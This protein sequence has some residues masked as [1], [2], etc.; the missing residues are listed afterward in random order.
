VEKK[1][2]QWRH[3]WLKYNTNLF[4]H[5]CTHSFNRH[6]YAYCMLGVIPVVWDSSVS[7]AVI[8]AIIWAY[9]LVRGVLEVLFPNSDQRNTWELLNKAKRKVLLLQK[10]AAQD[11]SLIGRT[12]LSGK[13]TQIIF[14]MWFPHEDWSTLWLTTLR[15][16][17]SLGV[18]ARFS[19]AVTFCNLMGQWL[20]M[21]Y[22]SVS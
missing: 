17:L 15:D 22:S 6:L 14:L 21:V 18:R 5:T 1:E 20:L 3:C 4:I 9:V 8:S 19:D 7:K 2:Q 12:H 10:G 16:W 11:H 13:S